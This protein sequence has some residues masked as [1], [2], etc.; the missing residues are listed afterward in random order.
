[1]GRALLGFGPSFASRTGLKALLAFGLGD[2]SSGV[3]ARA[4]LYLDPSLE[5]QKSRKRNWLIITTVLDVKCT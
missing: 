4:P 3:V 5:R 2:T 1:M